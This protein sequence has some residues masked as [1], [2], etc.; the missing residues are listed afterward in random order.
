MRMRARGGCGRGCAQLV[1]SAAAARALWIWRGRGDGRG[2]GWRTTGNHRAPPGGPSAA[3]HSGGALGLMAASRPWR[4]GAAAAAAASDVDAWVGEG[5][6]RLRE[7][8]AAGR[9]LRGGGV[10][11][12]DVG[13]DKAE[14]FGAGGAQRG[15]YGLRYGALMQLVKRVRGPSI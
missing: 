6:L 7:G 12:E 15:W 2:Q 5:A 8:F 3:A 1:R 14:S 11:V 9:G 4:V 10:V 13:V